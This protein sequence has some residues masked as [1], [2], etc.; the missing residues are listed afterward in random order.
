MNW[1]IP[2]RTFSGSASNCTPIPGITATSSR[3]SRIQ[4]TVPV[5][6]TAGPSPMLKVTSTREPMGIRFTVA[7]KSPPSE[8]SLEK[9]VKKLWS[10]S[11]STLAS[12]RVRAWVRRSSGL[13]A[14]RM[15]LA[16]AARR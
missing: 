4:R 8:M 6:E 10:L 15:G 9:P 14:G 1:W 3:I 2:L 7:M 5:T 12:K 11:K 16:A 13:R